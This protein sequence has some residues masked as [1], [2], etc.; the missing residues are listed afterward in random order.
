MIKYDWNKNSIEKVIKEAHSYSEALKLLK[1]PVQGNNIN[2][3]KNK[4]REF[5]LKLEI[6]YSKTYSNRNKNREV[7]IE[8]YLNNSKAISSTKLKLKLLALKIKENKCECCGIDSWNNKKLILQLH[9]IDGNHNNNNL[10]NLKLLCPNCH[11]QTDNYCN[12]IKIKNK[13]FCLS[14]GKEILKN[15]KYCFDCYLQYR[16][17]TSKFSKISKE[18]FIKISKEYSSITKL[19]SYFK[20]SDTAIKKWCIQWNIPTKIKELHMM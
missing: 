8:E 19:A 17:D 20:V 12:N 16:K 3:L 4:L 2:T 6:D 13:Y 18:E 1:I 11:S 10:T 5:N 7:N 9:H 15:S 14:C